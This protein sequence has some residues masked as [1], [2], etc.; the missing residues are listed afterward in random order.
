[1]QRNSAWSVNELLCFANIRIVI[2]SGRGFPIPRQ[3]RSDEY[4]KTINEFKLVEP[5]SGSSSSR[6]LLCVPE[7]PVFNLFSTKSEAI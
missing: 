7:N 2:F 5:K 4:R 1:M 3:S 6:L